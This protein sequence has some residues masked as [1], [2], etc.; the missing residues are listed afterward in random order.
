VTNE[1]VR[2]VLV[3]QATK[4][5]SG[6]VNT[7]AIAATKFK[8]FPNPTNDILQIEMPDN[9]AE[10]AIELY[11]PTGQLLL[12]KMLVSKLSTLSLEAYTEGIYLLV[13]KVGNEVVRHERVVVS[14]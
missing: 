6:M 9:L 11:S 1:V 10:A 8:L 5:F 13:L 12:S 7:E 4:Y 3:C 2:H 14:R